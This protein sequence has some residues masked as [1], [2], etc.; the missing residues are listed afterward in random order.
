M[1]L[2][3]RLVIALMVPLMLA[4]A[5]PAMSFAR[6]DAKRYVV[7]IPVLPGLWETSGIVDASGIFGGDSW[8]LD[9]QAHDPT[10]PPTE[11]TVE[12]GQ[13]VLMSRG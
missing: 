1:L 12:D 2:K 13:L 4:L 7:P 6:S 3:S 10:T 9:V 11:T 8:L 5:L